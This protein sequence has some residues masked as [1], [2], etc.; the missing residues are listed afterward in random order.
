MKNTQTVYNVQDAADQQG[1][2][3]GALCYRLHFLSKTKNWP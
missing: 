3:T 1:V 2:T